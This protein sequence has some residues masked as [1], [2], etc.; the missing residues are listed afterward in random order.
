MF[1]HIVA[2]S[3]VMIPLMYSPGPTNILV[4]SNGAS[5]GLRRSMPLIAGINLGLVL[6]LILIAFG[7]AH[8]FERYHV[9]FYVLYFSGVIYMFYLASV[10]L[11]S[12]VNEKKIDNA[13]ID[14]ASMMQGVLVEIL[15]PK[16]WL[17]LIMLFSVFSKPQADSSW[18]ILLFVSATL[19][20]N[21]INNFLW[22]F[23][24]VFLVKTIFVG[25]FS[26]VQNYFYGILLAAVAVWMLLSGV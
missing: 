9:L 20:L 3:L 22:S 26:K 8:L 15:N 18:L 5:F 14:C 13:R 17:S 2:W 6:Q 12:K 23:L 4:A 1:E 19:V 10:F 16:V 7:I 24:G 11:F 25:S 21:L